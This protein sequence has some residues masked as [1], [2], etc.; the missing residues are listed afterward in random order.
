MCAVILDE[1]LQSLG[2]Q[3][4]SS[5]PASVIVPVFPEGHLKW[6]G[7]YITC[8][9]ERGV[10]CVYMIYIFWWKRTV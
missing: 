10:Y 1:G 7:D 3:L 2:S 9:C 4:Q 8:A 6:M 5:P